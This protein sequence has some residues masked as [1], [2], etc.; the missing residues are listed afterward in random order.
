MKQYARELTARLPR[1]APEFEYAAFSEGGNFNWSEQ[2]A[3]PLAIARSRVDLVHFLSLYT[4]IVVPV[5]SIVTI[6]DLIHLHFPRYFKARVGLYYRTVVRRACARAARVITDDERTV[7]D[8]QRFLGVDPRKVRVIPLGVDEEFFNAQ[9]GSEET[10]HRER[11]YLLYVGNH[12]R[13]KSVQTLI[14]AWEALPERCAV[15]LL[16]TGPD[17]FDGAL[18]RASDGR[19]RAEAIGDVSLER[20]AGLYREARALVHPALCE[21]FGLP[22]LEAMAS[23]TAVVASAEATPRVL[24][25]ATLSFPAEDVGALTARLLDVLEDEGL[26]ARLVNEGRMLAR[27]L[28]WDRCARATADVYH[29]VTA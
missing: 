10:R 11:P 19:R 18:Q 17:D 29:E 28:T 22:L 23:G 1:V 7:E 8:L 27:Q 26:R 3:L 14:A 15:D 16:L 6:H 13:H 20:L 2:V 25:P 5:R 12:R 4:P 9:A 24:K 21:G